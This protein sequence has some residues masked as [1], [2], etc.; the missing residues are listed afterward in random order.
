MIRDPDHE[1]EPPPGGRAAERLRQHLEA[2]FPQPEP[3]SDDEAAEDELA[4]DELGV[5]E[6][7]EPTDPGPTG[8]AEGA[9]VEHDDHQER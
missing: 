7:G 6:L 9:Q 2:R 1:T 4:E 3:E 5:D 8:D